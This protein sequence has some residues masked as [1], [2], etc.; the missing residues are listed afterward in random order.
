MVEVGERL[1]RRGLRH[2]PRHGGRSL[3]LRRQGREADAEHQRRRRPESSAHG[4]PFT[5]LPMLRSVNFR[6]NATNSATAGAASTTAPARI[7]PY[8]FV[9]SA[10]DVADVVGEG[11]GERL[12]LGVLGDQERPQELVPR[13]DEGEQHRGQQRGFHQRQRDRPQDAELGGAV[14]L[15]GREQVVGQA[16]EELPE[17]EDRGGVDQ[18][19]RDHAEVGVGEAVVAHDHHVERDDEQ[20]ERHDLHQQHGREQRAAAAEV[21][22]GQRVAGEDAEHHGA[23]HH[24]AGEDQRVQQRLQQVDAA[25]DGDVV[26]EGDSVERDQAAERGVELLLQRPDQHVVEG[27][28]EHQRAEQQRGHGP[29]AL[30]HRSSRTLRLTSEIRSTASTST[31]PIAAATSGFPCSIPFWYI[32]NTGVSEAPLGPPPLVSR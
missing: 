20:L 30:P 10:G 24:A 13:T 19:G 28:Q 23:E 6:W 8:G 29:E 1:G 17:D 27:E 3:R 2:S 21:Q 31:T 5:P 7:A 26:V 32:T 4:H 22:P 14:D 9:G 15:G 25:V 18:V 12:Q 16:E 11:H